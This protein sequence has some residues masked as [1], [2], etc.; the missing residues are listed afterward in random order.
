[1]N[2]DLLVQSLRD[3]DDSLCTEAADELDRLNKKYDEVGRAYDAMSADIV[4]LVEDNRALRK[5]LW[6]YEH[7]N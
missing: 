6:K 5:N 2:Y 7:N 4:R 1:M 3:R